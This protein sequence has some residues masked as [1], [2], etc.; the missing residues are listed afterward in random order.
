MEKR[1]N[2]WIIALKILL[3][4]VT[5]SVETH[6]DNKKVRVCRKIKLWPWIS[7][8]SLQTRS[9]IGRSSPT[10]PALPLPGYLHSSLYSVPLLSSPVWPV[11][12]W[13]TV[14]LQYYLT[15]LQLVRQSRHEAGQLGGKKKRGS[16]VSLSLCLPA[17]IAHIER[18]DTNAFLLSN[19]SIHPL[20]I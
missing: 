12:V 8:L 18:T 19:R 20:F 3:S 2:H 11:W 13:V 4:S 1:V 5:V 14:S 10:C 9:L 6:L 15:Q 7:R 17:G 16:L